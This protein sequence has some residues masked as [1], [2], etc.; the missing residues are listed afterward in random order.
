MSDAPRATTPQSRDRNRATEVSEM[1]AWAE[2]TKVDM[3]IPRDLLPLLARDDVKQIEIV[4]RHV[5][6]GESGSGSGRRA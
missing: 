6:L 5:G 3:P 1:K 2:H 4:M